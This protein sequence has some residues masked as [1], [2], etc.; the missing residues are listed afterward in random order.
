MLHKDQIEALR[1]PLD[2]SRVKERPGPGGTRLSYLEGYDVIDK[3]N[4]IFLPGEWGHETLEVQYHEVADPSSG[5]VVGAFYSARVRLEVR[6]CIPVTEEGVCPVELIKGKG[7]VAEHDKGRKGAITDALKRCFRIYGEQ[8]GN[9]LYDR[10]YISEQRAAVRKAGNSR[11]ETVKPEHSSQTNAAQLAEIRELAARRKLSLQA[12]EKRCRE[13]YGAGVS[14]L[15]PE[16]ATDI[17]AKL[18]ETLPS[19]PVG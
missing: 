13:L 8:L 19:T 3:A 9:S 18:R 4:E 12:I 17:I 1:Q 6:G 5:E 14:G 7:L 16:Q 2:W 10:A 11:I 15:S